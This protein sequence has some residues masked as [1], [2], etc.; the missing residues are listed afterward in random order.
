VEGRKSVLPLSIVCG[1]VHERANTP[2]T[3]R[4]LRFRRARPRC[5]RAADQRDELASPHIGSQV[6]GP[7]LYPI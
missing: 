2:H 7:A 6:Q 1:P 3:F 4:R 5:C